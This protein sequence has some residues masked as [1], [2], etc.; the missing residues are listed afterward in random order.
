MSEIRLNIDGIEVKG[1]QG[2]TIL[3]IAKSYDIEIPT[4]CFDERMDIYGSCGMCV[5][6]V[7]GIPKL[8]RSCATQARDGMVVKTHTNRVVESR[9]IALELLLSD[10]V[11]DCRPPCILACPGQTD[12]QGY[13]GLVANGEFEEALK[14]VKEQLPLP[15]C[16]GRVC[17]HPCEDA[18]RRQ[19]V[20]E[21]IAIA[22]QKRFIADIDMNKE[23]MF[24]PDLSAPTGKRVAIVGGG[25]AGLTAAYFLAVKGHDVTIYDMMPQM[26]GMLRYGIPEY[27]LPK[28]VLD[29]EIGVIEK[30]GVS[31]IN[32][33]KAGKDF[34]ITSLKENYDSVFVGIGAWT[35]SSMRCE[36]EDME[37]VYG[38]IDFL[39]KAALK[40]ATNIGNRVAVIGGGNTAMDAARTAVRLG[41]KDVYLVYRRT[42]AEM[43]AEE[44]EIVEAREEGVKF[45]FL[46]SP[47]KVIAGENGRAAKLELQ[48][49]KLGEPD[50]SGRRRPLPIE[51]DIDIIEIDSV[52]SA[53]GQGCDPEGLPELSLTKKGTIS[54]DEASFMTN[55]EGVFAAGDATN[56]GANI[57]IQAIGDAKK[58][59]AVMDSYM[60]GAIIPFKEKYF[61][62][63]D[64]LTESDFADREKSSRGTMSHLS[65][66]TRKSN[67]EE[68]L[69]GFTPEEAMRDASRC[70]ECGCHDFFECKLFKYANEYDVEPEKFMGQVH[71][72]EQTDDH[73]FILKNADKCILCGQCVR[74]CDEVMGITALGLVNRGFETIVKPSLEQ[75]LV[76]SGCISCGQCVSVCPTGSLQEKLL[77]EKSVPVEAEVTQGICSYCSLGCQ[78]DVE[79][80]GNMLYRALPV[81]NNPVDGGLLCVKGKFGYDYHNT[82][83]S[84]TPMVKKDGKLVKAE[85]NEALLATSEAVKDL[86]TRYGK[87]SLALL[88]SDHLTNEEI[89][90]IKSFAKDSLGTENIASLSAKPS[91]L[92]DVFGKNAS[93]STMEEMSSSDL[94]VFIGSDILDTHT[95][96]GVKM[97]KAAKS[98]AKLVLATD[99][100]TKLDDS[101]YMALQIKNDLS[102]L[103]EVAHAIMQKVSGASRTEGFDEFKSSLEKS[104]PRDSA[105]KLAEL[106]SNAKKPVIVFD[107][108]RLTREAVR[109]IAGLAAAS[110]HVGK[111]REGILALKPANNSQGLADQGIGDASAIKAGIASGTIKGLMSFGEDLSGLDLEALDFLMQVGFNAE[112][113]DAKTHVFLP[114]SASFE[115]GGSFTNTE[116]RV[117]FFEKAVESKTGY[118]NW[119]VVSEMAA[120]LEKP[121]GFTG[122]LNIFE[123]LRLANPDYISINERGFWSD[124]R[125]DSLYLENFAT[126]SGKA[127]LFPAEDGKLFETYQSKYVLE[128]AFEEYL[129][130]EDLK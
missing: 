60:N 117:Q 79:T 14:L 54:A 38:G 127:L 128:K 129:E 13:V 84:L 65:P 69:K 104:A 35:S 125:G 62:V 113:A 100:P 122:T 45:I 105:L 76:S 33:S 94:I 72:R 10:H 41:A 88:V 71:H 106:Y 3:E 27:R 15:G 126:E 56:K 28:E 25:P 42:E 59:V 49:M 19:L 66:E 40:E 5:V 91:G 116:R 93:P 61:V 74:I 51:G 50:A 36:G 29:K 58:A 111:A 110:G 67:F 24:I 97:R 112:K 20:E 73:P 63:R 115:T 39:R 34:T 85:W 77:I 90:I 78:L 12:C 68:I 7:E 11:G 89:H 48:N 30:M 98:G 64:D 119:Q 52:I 21:P 124:G 70:L 96:M 108:A 86:K 8:L 47:K 44:V 23:N 9:K 101:A 82:D 53:I 130:K 18:C 22:W 99:K 120:M 6:E 118:E 109:L 92:E 26:G 102:F 87:D 114:A 121:M 37:G 83:R 43:P 46:A 75:P 31:L 16:I 123:S 2:D 81:K 1:H 32:N 95:T 4:L 17:P 107:E 103:K 55:V 57:A 80:K